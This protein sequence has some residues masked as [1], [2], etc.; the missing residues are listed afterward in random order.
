VASK[1]FLLVMLDSKKSSNCDY[2]SHYRLLMQIPNFECINSSRLGVFVGKKSDSSPS[3]TVIVVPT[4][5][6]IVVL[7]C[8]CVCFFYLR[9]RKKGRKL[10]VS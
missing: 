5:V 6:P 3:A 9:V 4:V 8:M 1:L 2:I 10:K 7:I